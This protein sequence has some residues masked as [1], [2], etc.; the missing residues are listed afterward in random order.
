MGSIQSGSGHDASRFYAHI[1]ARAKACNS[2][3]S[4]ITV[5]GEDCELDSIGTVADITSG[6]VDVVDPAT[7]GCVLN[8]MLE[9]KAVASDAQ[10]SLIAPE[11]WN[12]IADWKSE[13]LT[14][15]LGCITEDRTLTAVV[16]PSRPSGTENVTE[17]ADHQPFQLQLEFTSRTGARLLYVRTTFVEVTHD[18]AKSERGLRPSVAAVAA[19]QRAATLAHKGKYLDARIEMLST[20]RLLQRAMDLNDCLSSPAKTAVALEN[21]I[22]FILQG[23][24]LDGFMR[25]A[26][27]TADQLNVPT[28]AK[29]DDSASRAMYLMKTLSIHDFY[30]SIQRRAV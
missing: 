14:T 11:G 22:G 13:R 2:V 24:A 4:V 26:L 27:A 9:K 23:E 28:A 8:T 3:V 6:G 12:I 16:N 21:L 15:T 30:R 29:R 18:R 17:A 7:M 19:L 1:G 5:D 10:L 20:L 25:E